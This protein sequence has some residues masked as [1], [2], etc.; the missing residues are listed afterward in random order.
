[1]STISELIDY[2]RLRNPV[3]ALL[4]TSEWGSGKT[5]LIDNTLKKALEGECIIIRVS[6][7]GVSSIN[8]V[9]KI[10]KNKWIQE[11]GG[12]QSLLN[13]FQKDKDVIAN[14]TQMIPNKA[15]QGIVETVLSVDFSDYV[16]VTSKIGDKKVILVF[17]DLE[18]STLVFDDLNR[19]QLDWGKFVGT[20]NEYCENKNFNVILIADE[21]KLEEKAYEVFKEKVIQ[22][23]VFHVPNYSEIV[24][25]VIS[26]LQD[27]DYKSFLIDRKDE[28]TA[29]FSGRDVEGTSL[30]IKGSE[31][32]DSRIFLYRNDEK[33]SD[34]KYELIK[35]RPHN[36]RSLK[37]AIQEFERLFIMFDSQDKNKQRYLYSFLTYSMALKANLVRR[38]EKENLFL[39]MMDVQYIYPGFFDSRYMPEP[40]S[41]WL[42]YGSFDEKAIKESIEERYRS[43]FHS[44]P[45]DQVKSNRID[46]L[47]EDIAIEGYRLLLIDAYDGQLSLN[48]YVML[49]YNSYLFRYYNFKDISINWEK[50]CEGINR[51]IEISI[52]NGEGLEYST[53]SLP[54]SLPLSDEERET[55]KIIKEIRETSYV[56]YE[57]NRRDYIKYMN[58]NPDDVFS[59][60]SGKRFCC[61]DFDM[62]KATLC[63]FE[64]VDNSTKAQFFRHFEGMWKTY[65]NSP[66]INKENIIKTK[67]GFESLKE[68]LGDL[69]N[70]FDNKPI[71]KFYTQEF[72]SVLNKLIT[73]SKSEDY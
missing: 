10:I 28:I 42:L 30:D 47:D 12:L 16:N 13:K 57:Q 38:T 37:S 31:L 43:S 29:L 54:E 5:Y 33:E 63:A 14:G 65:N 3:G 15:V 55:Y 32:I 44:S 2:C 41:I 20:I 67:L 61:F 60:V 18:R 45:K 72:I 40:I 26:S 69:C 66:D 24:M 4:L 9:H 49:I 70:Q 58:N 25:G 23:T 35:K 50:V 27:S 1:M 22:R 68:M 59:K 34:Q 6:L 56:L 46:Y 39:E 19:S 8:G 21:G 48:E 17:D 73:T 36:I 11:K 62:A 52:S 71:K 53:S 51:R 64:T 7:F